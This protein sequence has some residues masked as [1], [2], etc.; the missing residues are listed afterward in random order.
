MNR[1]K[2]RRVM[3]G[4]VP[5]GG[6]APVSIQSMTN[7]DTRDA[8]ATSAQIARLAEAG[9]EIV[10]CAVP[11]MR[12]AEALD[13]IV[14]RSPIPVAA[15]IHFDHRLALRAAEAGVAKIRINPGNIGSIE[16]I[17]LI[18][19]SCK[20]KDV[21]IRI[22]VNGGSLE[23]ELLAKYGGPSAEGM[24][25][26]ALRQAEILEDLG[27]YDIIVSLKSSSVSE[28]VRANLLFAE[29]SDIPLHI[30]VTEAG[31]LRAGTIKSAAGIGGMLALG[32]GETL[33]VS[34]TDDPVREIEL[35]LEILRALGIRK[36]RPEVIS[37]PTC[38]RTEV[39]IIGL[40]QEV[41]RQ[42][43]G[44]EGY[45]KV[46]VMGCAVN[47]PGEAREADIGI[48][49]GAGDAVLFVKGEILKKLSGDNLAGQLMEEIRGRF[50]SGFVV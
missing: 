6:G 13:E 10:R 33:R 37:C 12:A 22:G 25:E 1:Q 34:L 11:D 48:A 5:V 2:T 8:A 39:D 49:G 16:R 32:V 42:L 19:E 45:I 15:D 29:A 14:K 27:F 3:V 28:T 18:V 41:E 40:A 7:T 23:R 31:T 4:N 36:D 30:G 20:A 50:G 17:K 47:G 21:A 26:S 43:A 46:A 9:C 24:V 38:G 44:F 35:G